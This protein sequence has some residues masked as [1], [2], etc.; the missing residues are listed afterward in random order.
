VRQAILVAFM[1]IAAV[2]VAHGRSSSTAG[3][4]DSVSY[5]YVGGNTRRV[6]G[7][8]AARGTEASGSFI[9]DQVGVLAL[10][11][12]R[13][14]ADRPPVVMTPGFGLAGHIYLTTA[15]GRRGWAHSF[16]AA[17]RAAYLIDRSHTARTGF[18]VFAFNDARRGAADPAEQPRFVLWLDERIWT[19]W[20]LGPAFGERFDD[21][22]FPLDSIEQLMGAFAP[23]VSESVP[24]RDQARGNAEGLVAL[25]ERIGP[26]VILTH[27]ASGLDGF[28]VATERPDL[29]E[30]IV[31]IE[32][33]GCD[34]AQASDLAGIPVLS[35]FG[36][37]LEVRPQM[38]PRLQEC[39]DLTRSLAE[40]DGR[41][42]TRVLPSQGINGNSHI[43]MSDLN[44]DEIAGLILE[45]LNDD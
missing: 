31:T 24:L 26:A 32:P 8:P 16:L 21:G 37:H 14:E 45:W 15:D 13:G 6:T 5:F 20:G 34:P 33:V 42:E 36:D 38:K 43:M 40:I 3:A 27:S 35:V 44:S 18:D 23:V 28:R 22:Q 11:P 1:T 4:I 2:H 25:L 30:S 10:E 9:V 39:L 41:S 17:G 29:V 12:V 7:Q 19:R